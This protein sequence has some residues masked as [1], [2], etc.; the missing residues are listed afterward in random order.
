MSTQYNP[1]ISDKL[2]TDCL[3]SSEAPSQ[4][5]VIYDMERPPLLE[6]DI[7]GSSG[8][9]MPESSDINILNKENVKNE[10]EMTNSAESFDATSTESINNTGSLMPTRSTGTHLSLLRNNR[11]YRLFLVSYALS[12]TGEYV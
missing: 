3:P 12:Q 6:S 2:K 11:P 4:V 7:E 8:N 1:K 10:N 9:V 5:A